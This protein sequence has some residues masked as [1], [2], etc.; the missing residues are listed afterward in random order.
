MDIQIQK[1][2]STRLTLPMSEWY[3]EQLCISFSVQ[4]FN[5]IQV[6]KKNQNTTKTV[7]GRSTQLKNNH[8]KTTRIDKNS[9]ILVVS[10]GREIKVE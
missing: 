5:R 4:I 7:L 9:D 6:L 1:P 10:K 3:T 8:M 2:F